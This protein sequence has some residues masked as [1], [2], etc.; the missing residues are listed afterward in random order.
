MFAQLRENPLAQLRENP[1]PLCT[2]GRFADDQQL[3]APTTTSPQAPTRTD[4]G[5]PARPKKKKQKKKPS[6][7]DADLAA[8]TRAAAQE[9]TNLRAA[10]R[11]VAIHLK[12]LRVA[13]AI[14]LLLLVVSA[15][16]GLAQPMAVRLVLDRLANAE[17]LSNAVLILIGLVVFSAI[18]Q[19]GGNF[20]MQRSAEDVVLATRRR[21]ITKLISITVPEMR[22]KEPGDLMARVTSDTA[23]I[24]QIALNSLV[25]F[26]TGLVM[27]IGSI[28]MM[29]ILDVIL[30]A[31]TLGVV[32]VVGLLLGFIMPRIRR[33]SQQTQ[34]NVGA[35]GAELE[36]ILGAYT[37][38]K[39]SAAED[40]ERDRIVERMTKAHDSGIRTALWSSLAA[41]TSTL[42]IQ[43]SFLVVLGYGGYRASTG[44]IAIPTLIAF[45]LYAMQLSSPVLQLTQA[46]STFQS[47]RAALERIAEVDTF[48]SELDAEPGDA[49]GTLAE[50][51]PVQ[52]DPAVHFR[53]VSFSYPGT[54]GPAL[55]RINL[56]IPRT[57]LTAI[58]GPSGSGKSSVLKLIEGFYP[59]DSGQLYVGGRDLV[60]WDLDRLRQEVGY[61][62]Q[63]SPAP[64]ADL[65]GNLTYGIDD[66]DKNAAWQVL[67]RVGLAERFAD[68][69][70]QQDR[71]ELGHRGSALSGG[72][73]QR[74][75][76]ARALLR[77][78]HLLLLDE[79]TSAQDAGNEENLR[80]LVDD[81]SR[82]IAV[83]VVAHR[84]STIRDADQIVV[85]EDGHIRAIGTHDQLVR[86]DR[87]YHDL[88]RAQDTIAAT[89]GD[90]AVPA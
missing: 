65:W 45:L 18:C 35:M 3:S 87:L 24:R 50:L 43:A 83:V 33:S 82:E 59:I 37:T 17:P 58:V 66:V 79:A 48:E 34:R 67:R 2:C 9:K 15:A 10:F 29:V 56:R 62:E 11:M 57:G 64:A 73:R 14:G 89:G 60:E 7:S 41:M 88:V 8:R 19:G 72:E 47:G 52:W 68:L 46:V 22:G 32:V 44:G 25:Q 1:A 49:P 6:N 75:A 20:L 61:V 80:G 84:L 69:E 78:P 4:D 74:L 31:V 5:A 39:A 77:R 38:V 90:P 16:V 36:R 55:T 42:A 13:M 53:D 30:F 27:V 85:L 40:R 63:D 23:L 26:V 21:L 12:P 71:G 51:G 28:V 70:R 86:R 54:D 76:V 81:V